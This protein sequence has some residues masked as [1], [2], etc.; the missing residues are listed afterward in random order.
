MASFSS[1]SSSLNSSSFSSDDEVLYDM[2]QKASMLFHVGFVACIYGDLFIATK[3]EEGGGH[4][5]D[6]TNG[7]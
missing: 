3:M 7:V 1:S 6:P 4:S 2:D 5:R